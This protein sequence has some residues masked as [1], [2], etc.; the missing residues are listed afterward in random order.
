AQPAYSQ[1]RGVVVVAPA[2]T[3]PTICPAIADACAHVTMLQRSPTFFITGRNV[4][5]LA[6][7]LRQLE[8][9]E[10]WIHEIVRRKILY[11]QAHFTRRCVDEPDVVAKEL[12][13][14]VR[15]YLRP[16]YNVDKHFTPNYRPWRQRIAFIP[17]ADLFK[18]IAGGK[19]S[20]IT[21]VIERFNETG[22]LLKSA[23][24]PDAHIIL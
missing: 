16:D 9:D 2:A 12:I 10:A 23:M 15:N 21:D 8:V 1:H 19:V 17:D 20:V 6:E 3:A 11:D 4:N 5:D 14:V 18:G 24:Q 22:I 7:T 13:G